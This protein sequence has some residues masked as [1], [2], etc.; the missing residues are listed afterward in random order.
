V[1]QSPQLVILFLSYGLLS[2]LVFVRVRCPS[3]WGWCHLSAHRFV[4]ELANVDL[5]S[6]ACRMGKGDL[7][8][9]GGSAA[10][11]SWYFESGLDRPRFC[12]NPLVQIMHLRGRIGQ[13]VRYGD[14]L[15]KDCG[16]WLLWGTG[17]E[18]LWST[19]V[20]E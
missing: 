4:K 19:D 10:G 15:S 8:V 13:G 5:S 20:S 17:S 6:F 1:V 7:L 16:H 11:V 14:P 2:F 9:R 3:I 12:C 18:S